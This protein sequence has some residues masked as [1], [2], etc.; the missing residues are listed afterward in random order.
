MQLSMRLLLLLSCCCID[1]M[2]LVP[3]YVCVWGGG[4]D[5]TVAAARQHRWNCRCHSPVRLDLHRHSAV[6]LY[7]VLGG[8]FGVLAA[9]CSAVRQC[10][11]GSGAQH[12]MQPVMGPLL[13]LGSCLHMKGFSLRALAVHCRVLSN[14]GTMSAAVAASLATGVGGCSRA[15]CSCGVPT[16]T[17]RSQDK[18]DSMLS[19]GTIPSW[20]ENPSDSKLQLSVCSL[21]PNSSFPAF[22]GQ[23]HFA[24]RGE[25]TSTDMSVS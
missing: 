4:A 23:E 18:A 10:V 17:D 19:G 15:G 13:R 21:P 8:A 7:C 5:S 11:V 9:V 25:K 22:I 20:G 3:V 24:S 12:S 6:F 1:S 2:W 16:V 14:C